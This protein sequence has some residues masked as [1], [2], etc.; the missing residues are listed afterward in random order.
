MTVAR[1]HIVVRRK[2]K[3]GADGRDGKG[4]SF[5]TISYATSDSSTRT[6]I[7]GWQSIMPE[8]IDNYY[9]WTR[10]VI[11]YTDGTTSTSYSVARSGK[12]IKTVIVQYAA[13]ASG[14]T[15]PSSGWQLNIP[16]VAAGNYLWTRTSTTYTDNT[17]SVSYSVSRN[18]TNGTNGQD[19]APGRDGQDGAPG[20]DGPRGYSGCVYRLT[21]WENGKEYRNDSSLQTNNIKY[22]D[23]A[24]DVSIAIVGQ[25]AFHAYMCKVTHTSSSSKPLGHST[26]WT[27]MTSMAPM[28][29][30][31][32]LSTAISADY[33]NVGEIA[34]N[35]A[36]IQALTAQQA[37]IDSAVIRVLKTADTGKRIIIQN[38]QMAM[39]DANNRQK[40]LIKGED[41]DI[42][43]PAVSYS[44]EHISM[45]GHYEGRGR[46]GQD[47]GSMTICT[48]LVE[49]ANT[50]VIIP[51]LSIHGNVT[52]QG[53]YG[54]TIESTETTITLNKDGVFYSLLARG[55]SSSW[56]DVT[57]GG[58]TFN[59]QPGTYTIGVESS[60]EWEVDSEEPY[61]Q[62]NW[63]DYVLE[64]TTTGNILVASGTLQS[65]QIGA[66]GL[67]IH[68]GNAFSAVF[69]LDGNSRPQIMM[70]GINGS[71][72]PI[73][74]RIT[75]SGVQIN[76]G[77]GWVNL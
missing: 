73:G 37:F 9:L 29:T 12:G 72:Q 31:M 68:L 56:G 5:V 27:E 64:N 1:G 44:T 52:S 43:T 47:R 55:G 40:L 65:I 8:I 70:Q 6:P 33:I 54:G 41:I 50:Q 48:F 39:F 75:S 10:T 14:T 13:S 4:V 22:I 25:Q 77:T 18:G 51:V 2:A 58:A 59:L 61:A 66:N 67:A 7:E 19:G 17:N 49:T 60:W 35:A 45:G 53:G 62:H 46:Q 20:A 15:P 26:Y 28:I 42:G 38:N 11:T 57:Y 69:A 36:F 63:I 76:R 71:S 3:D 30:P 32:L 16:V 21:V 24:V 23:I 74:L 34:A